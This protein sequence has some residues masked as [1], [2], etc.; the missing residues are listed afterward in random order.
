MSFIQYLE[1]CYDDDEFMDEEILEALHNYTF[2]HQEERI[3]SHKMQH[4]NQQG[5]TYENHVTSSEIDVKMQQ[6]CQCFDHKE[7]ENHCKHQEEIL[8][9]RFYNP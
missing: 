3:T 4:E 6:T 5:F 1:D 8:E 7:Y 2:Q 9:D